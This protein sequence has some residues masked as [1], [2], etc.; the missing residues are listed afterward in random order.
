MKVIDS[1]ITW[2]KYRSVC[3]YDAF[4]KDPRQAKREFNYQYFRRG[5]SW[6]GYVTKINY[7]EDNPMSLA[8]HSASILVKMDLDDRTGAHGPDLGLSISEFRL[9]EIAEEVGS[10]HRG[11][12]IR[13]NAT[14]QS[15]GDNSHLHHLH[16]W[17]IEK[18]SGH[19]D[20]EAH[21]YSNGRYKVRIEPHDGKDHSHD[22]PT[23]H[24]IILA[25][26]LA[27]ENDKAPEGGVE[28]LLGDLKA[29]SNESTA[30]SD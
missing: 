21:A 22:E 12:H 3:G 5:V 16:V 18:I 26:D 7:N 6:D 24:A 4:H 15:M 1:G 23:D 17:E 10:L 30:E 13:F 11:D 20:V 29:K 9:N 8:Y 2:R 25:S 27:T 19:R 28:N 14:M